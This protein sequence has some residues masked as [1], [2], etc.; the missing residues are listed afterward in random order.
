[1]GQPFKTFEGDGEDAVGEVVAAN[2]TAVLS[3]DE[4]IGATSGQP[5]QSFQ[6]PPPGLSGRRGPASRRGSVLGAPTIG[7][8]LLGGA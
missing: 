3:E 5:V 6:A 7:R 4:P 2:E 1:M 8:S